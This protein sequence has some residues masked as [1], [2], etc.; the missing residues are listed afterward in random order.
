MRVPFVHSHKR[1]GAIL[2][3]QRRRWRWVAKLSAAGICKWKAGGPSFC[4]LLLSTQLNKY[5][6]NSLDT[7]KGIC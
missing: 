2:E 6:Q 3:N 7:T 4:I 1:L 5:F